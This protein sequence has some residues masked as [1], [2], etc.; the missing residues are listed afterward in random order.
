[1]IERTV[2]S[3]L[4]W[5]HRPGIPEKRLLVW[6]DGIPIIVQLVWS[7]RSLPFI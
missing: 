2:D 6:S 4:S 1:M 3:I 7:T 5:F